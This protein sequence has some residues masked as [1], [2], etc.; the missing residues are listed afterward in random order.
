MTAW[1]RDS[2]RSILQ[3]KKLS[4]KQS[5]TLFYQQVLAP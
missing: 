4:A 3:F 5:T 1:E 2:C